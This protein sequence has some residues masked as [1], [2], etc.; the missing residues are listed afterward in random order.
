[1]FKYVSKLNNVLAK[2]TTVEG[3][4]LGAVG[5]FVRSEA[6]LRSAVGEHYG[7]NLRDSNDYRIDLKRMKVDI[8]N[9]A[10]HAPYVELGTGIYAKDGNG[11]TTPWVYFNEAT[12]S[13]VTTQGQEPKPFL[14]PSVMENKAR[15]KHLIEANLNFT[16]IDFDHSDED[17]GIGGGSA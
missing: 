14:E 1:M 7:G 11:R 10:E 6:Q 3:R 2:L 17:A 12:Q 16:S 15:I 5:E 8:G 13:F 4:A 9:Y